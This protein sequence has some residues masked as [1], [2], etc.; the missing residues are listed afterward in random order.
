[1]EQMESTVASIDM[2]EQA[3]KQRGRRDRQTK[4]VEKRSDAVS[5]KQIMHQMI[6]PH[7]H[8]NKVG[9][10][11]HSAHVALCALLLSLTLFSF[12]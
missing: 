8:R 11:L 4:E 12:L 6:Y 5:N 10:M 1:M 9:R 7:K 3:D 2:E